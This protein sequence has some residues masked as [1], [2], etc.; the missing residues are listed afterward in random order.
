MDYGQV[1]EGAPGFLKPF[2]NNRLVNGTKEFLTSNSL[3]AKFAFLLLTLFAFLFLLRLGV[4]LLGYFLGPSNSPYLIKGMIDSKQM[5]V[6]PQ[7]PNVKGSKPIYRSTNQRDGLEFTW[8]VWININDL[9]YNEGQYKHIFHKGNDKINNKNKPYGLNF[10]N[11]GPG[12][13]IAP[14][15]NDLVV[16]MNTFN[17]INEEVIIKDVPLNKWIN[18]MIVVENTTLD[19]YINGTIARRHEL[20]S[21]PKQNYGNVYASMNGGFSGYTSNLRYFNKAIGLNEIQSIVN[22][23]PNMTMT[24]KSMTQSKPPYFALRWFFFEPSQTETDLY[25]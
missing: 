1:S 6:I 23:G 22:D 16:I 20:S 11:N 12:L 18:V 2:E 10:P 24:A 9:K 25:N 21:V 8:S 13:Y 5:V 17:N 19:V 7:D 14:N 15:T 3:V 4:S